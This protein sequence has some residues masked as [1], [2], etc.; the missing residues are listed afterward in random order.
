MVSEPDMGDELFLD[1]VGKSVID[2]GDLIS[3]DKLPYH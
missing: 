2:V 3:T 1:L